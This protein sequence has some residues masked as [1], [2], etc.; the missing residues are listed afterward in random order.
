MLWNQ[1]KVGSDLA[2]SGRYRSATKG[3]EH[4]DLSTR[5]LLCPRA[6][7]QARTHLFRSRS[8]FVFSV[9]APYRSAGFRSAA[10]LNPRLR[11]DFA[12]GL[13]LSRSARS[14]PRHA[15]G[16]HARERLNIQLSKNELQAVYPWGLGWNLISWTSSNSLQ[17]S[18]YMITI[19]FIVVN[20]LLSKCCRFA[21]TF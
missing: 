16:R 6:G 20:G 13:P 14:F 19:L 4:P 7:S 9:A 1:Q 21:V 11:R 18:D 5:Q 15:G 17:D 12:R 2:I 3:Y 8:R 10:G